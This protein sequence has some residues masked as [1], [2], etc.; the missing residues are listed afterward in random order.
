VRGRHRLAAP[1]AH[2]RHGRP[3]RGRRAAADRDVGCRARPGPG[4]GRRDRAERG[5]VVWR[6]G[7]LTSRPCAAK[8]VG[9]CATCSRPSPPASSSFR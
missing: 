2:C 1:H 6:G 7:C 9:P 8:L 3:G 5:P 4:S